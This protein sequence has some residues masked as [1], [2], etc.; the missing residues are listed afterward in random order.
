MGNIFL[1]INNYFFPPLE[2]VELL[3][4][5]YKYKIA[6]DKIKNPSGARNGRRF[7]TEFRE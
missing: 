6:V 4:E 5:Q 2:P 3:L 1:K 7:F